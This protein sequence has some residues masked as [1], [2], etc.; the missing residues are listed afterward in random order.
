MQQAL[1]SNNITQF[2]LNGNTANSFPF[3]TFRYLFLNKALNKVEE[4]SAA[5]EK[6]VMGSQPFYLFSFTVNAEQMMV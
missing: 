2:N 1:C 4:Y 5:S 6:V 3:Y